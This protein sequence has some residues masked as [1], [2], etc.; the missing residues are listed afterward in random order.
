MCDMSSFF[1]TQTRHQ[2]LGHAIMTIDD[3][4]DS[5][6]FEPK[7]D[8]QVCQGKSCRVFAGGDMAS[9]RNAMC[10]ND[11]CTIQLNDVDVQVTNIPL[12]IRC[13]RDGPRSDM[14]CRLK[15]GTAQVRQYSLTRTPEDGVRLQMLPSGSEHPPPVTTHDIVIKYHFPPTTD[16]VESEPRRPS[17][18]GSS[19]PMLLS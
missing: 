9:T 13:T 6:T 15:D 10:D 5:F 7:Y 19:P 12:S 8:S 11:H 3:S 18:P 16:D 14:T 4:P 2:R 1:N 17:P